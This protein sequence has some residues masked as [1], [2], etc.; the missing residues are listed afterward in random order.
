MARGD[1]REPPEARGS[2]LAGPGLR[3]APCRRSIGPDRQ[4]PLP[5]RHGGASPLLIDSTGI[6]AAGEGEGSTRRHGAS[7][8][9]PWREV[10]LGIDAET[11][12]AHAIE[13]VQASATGPGE[14]ANGS[15]VGDAPMPFDL[16]AA[17]PA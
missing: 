10:P 2:G 17:D 7:R 14:P 8:P 16:R 3:A 12:E 9:C 5:P 4:G 15:R 1:D 6:K 11:L 13:G